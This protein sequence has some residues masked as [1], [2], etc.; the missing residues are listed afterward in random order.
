MAVFVK[1]LKNNL[2]T[3]GCFYDKTKLVHI[4]KFSQSC[5]VNSPKMYRRMI[6]NICKEQTNK[7]IIIILFP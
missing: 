3:V 1:S 5:H 4:V 2:D 7:K 6:H